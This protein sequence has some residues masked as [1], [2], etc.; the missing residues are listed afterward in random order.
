MYRLGEKNPLPLSYDVICCSNC[1]FAY[2][3]VDASQKIYDEYYRECN[4]YAENSTLKVA[5]DERQ[6]EFAQVYKVFRDK[7][8]LDANIIDI[9]CGN[10]DFLGYL[11]GKGFTNL[12]GM[13]PSED[14]VKKLEERGVHGICKGVFEPL[15][16]EEKNKYDIVISIG[17]IEHIY[18]LK[19]YMSQILQFMPRD[20]KAY[21]L[22]ECPAAEGFEKFIHPV[23]DYFNHEHIN[24]FSKV[25]L[26]NL[27]NIF[28]LYRVNE[29]VYVDIGS[30]NSRG[31]LI[32][33]LYELRDSKSEIKYDNL[34]IDSIKNYFKA[35][36]AREMEL[37][38]KIR[39]LLSTSKTLIIWGGGA[40]A[41]QIIKKFPEL[42][43]KADCFIDNNSAKQGF[44]IG[45]KIVYGP[46]HIENSK[47]IIIAI[48]SMMNAQDIE[49][50]IQR[51][52]PNCSIVIL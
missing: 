10:G 11:K 48:C 32:I 23:P 29:E 5:E 21:F 22:C 41:M 34:S 30:G 44:R 24:Y 12:F 7:I 18:D 42:V 35:V 38:D 16:K 9:G 33:A 50:Q 19:N 43:K 2:A 4:M 1:G 40:Y 46:E 26:D 36:S 13:D 37:E 27:L 45:E 31:R 52:V 28:G 47:D 49:A 15:A 17:V 25:S 20:R 51:I 6:E 14:S 8:G 3:D 39:D